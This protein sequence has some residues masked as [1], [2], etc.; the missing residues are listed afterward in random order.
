MSI[1]K[2]S[3]SDSNAHHVKRGVTQT[4]RDRKYAPKSGL[5]VHESSDAKFVEK[6]SNKDI[7]V[8]SVVLFRTDTNLDNISLHDNLSG[9]AA[10]AKRIFSNYRRSH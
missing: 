9:K 10:E 4:G 6:A 1:P 3:K 2:A 8:Q 7:D 5:A